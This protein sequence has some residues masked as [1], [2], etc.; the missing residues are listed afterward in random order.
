MRI[1]VH[2]VK[3]T[4]E[5]NVPMLEEKAWPTFNI[6]INHKDV[7]YGWSQS[8]V[9]VIQVLHTRII[10]P[11]LYGPGFVQFNNLEECPHT[12]KKCAS[13]PKEIIW[14]PS[15]IFLNIFL[16][17]KVLYKCTPS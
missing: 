4:F 7:Q 12:A 15:F 6:P 17:S 3:R 1:C 13:T 9:Q 16:K 5:I 10:K 2:S 8:C 11:H 14:V